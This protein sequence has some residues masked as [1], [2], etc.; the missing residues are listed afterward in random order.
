MDGE[1]P[2]VHV[3]ASVPERPAAV[4]ILLSSGARGREGMPGP[5]PVPPPAAGPSLSP[6]KIFTLMDQLIAASD[7]HEATHGTHC[8]GL[9]DR[10]GMIVT[11]EDIGR[12]NTLDM[13]GGHMLLEA[14]R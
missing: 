8:S 12:H 2:S 3:T 13:L 4:T 10:S 11:R 9:A 5:G 6:G 14:S 1:K 7:L